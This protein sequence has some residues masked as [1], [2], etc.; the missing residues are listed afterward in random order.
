MKCEVCSIDLP[1]WYLTI[2]RPRDYHSGP[3]D[4]HVCDNCARGILY[5]YF[6]ENPETRVARTWAKTDRALWVSEAA[7]VWEQSQ[8]Y[9]DPKEV[10]R[11]MLGDRIR[12]KFNELCPFN[13]TN[14]TGVWA[15]F[16]NTASTQ[17]MWD[18]VADLFL[19]EVKGYK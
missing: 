14:L 17:I 11:I 1:T 18:R 19:R 9:D 15:V 13:Y 8:V 2:K 16:V 6:S 10:A 7:E 4:M 5:N 3:K 12:H